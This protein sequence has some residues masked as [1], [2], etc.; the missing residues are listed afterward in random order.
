MDPIHRAVEQMSRHGKMKK[1]SKAPSST[2]QGKYNMHP[3]DWQGTGGGR[4]KE[5]TVPC[6]FSRSHTHGSY[7]HL[8]SVCGI[9]I[10]YKFRIVT[11][12]LNWVIWS[13]AMQAGFIQRTMCA[14]E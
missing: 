6:T 9:Q 13:Q 12:T 5:G 8:M 4:L 7:C 3:R 11:P 14:K 10:G 1:N 2:A